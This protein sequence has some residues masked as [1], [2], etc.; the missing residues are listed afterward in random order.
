LDI[1]IIAPNDFEALEKKSVLYQ[2]ENYKE[3]NFFTRVI[4]LFPFNRQEIITKIDKDK[5]FYQ[6][7]WQFKFQ[8]L[9]KFRV[10]KFIGTLLIIFKLLFVFPFII[11][12]FNIKVIRATDPYL[13]GLIGLYY[14]KIFQIPFVVSVHTDYEQ[15]N[16]SGEKFTLLKSEKLPLILK[17]YIYTKCDG[18]LPI[19]KYLINII[20]KFDNNI[21]KN[22]FHKFPHGINVEEFD[23]IKKINILK[24]FD[25]PKEKKIISYVARLTK[26]KNCLDIPLIVEELSK[27]FDNFLF[28]IIGDGKEFETIQNLLVEK[29]LMS[30]VKM[31][32]FQSKEIVFNARKASDINICLLDG[33]SLIEAG[34]SRKP[35]VAYDVEWHSDLIVDNE[36]G[37]LV[38]LHDINNFADKI[39][40]L[41]CNE[42]LSKKFGTKLREYT[43][44]NQELKNTQLIKQNIF[45]TLLKGTG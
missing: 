32:G 39:F 14:S 9:N 22:K 21:D 35:V 13:M 27:R 38:Q 4:S 23:N 33:Y 1:L 24:K 19:S 15:H 6:Y 37:F 40:E 8:Y 2:Y 44:K 11:K 29:N 26:G 41:C 12:K 25:L 34:L 7:G 18:I 5:L 3:G 30:Y 45:K 16:D 20:Q 31:V 28:L 42:E 17:K 36:T 43:I 10:I